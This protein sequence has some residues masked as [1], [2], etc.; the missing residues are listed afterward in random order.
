MEVWEMCDDWN[1]QGKTVL[2]TGMLMH[3]EG[4]SVPR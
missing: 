4:N 3:V 2:T 1:H